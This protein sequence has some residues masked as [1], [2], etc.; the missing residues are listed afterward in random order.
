M[1]IIDKDRLQKAYRTLGYHTLWRKGYINGDS[2]FSPKEISD[3][4]MVAMGAIQD[5][6]TMATE[7]DLAEKSID[8]YREIAEKQRS[9]SNY[10]RAVLARHKI[11]HKKVLK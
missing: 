6:F 2:P 10:L 3:A 11:K 1:V 5:L 7:R 4:M 8:T 9:Y